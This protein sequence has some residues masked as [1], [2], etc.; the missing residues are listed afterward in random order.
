ME[1]VFNSAKSANEYLARKRAAMAIGGEDEEKFIEEIMR[2]R[3][4]TFCELFNDGNLQSRF[5]G[6]L[7][8]YGAIG[9][10][11][12]SLDYD[13]YQLDVAVKA[14]RP[15]LT[16]EFTL[17]EFAHR[18]SLVEVMH[19]AQRIA[20]SSLRVQQESEKAA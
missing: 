8:E 1:Y 5:W 7:K 15:D 12:R 11:R 10:L 13:T 19:A 17:I 4:K 6:H 20:E 2:Q 3:M 9:L 14:G 16:W 18:Y